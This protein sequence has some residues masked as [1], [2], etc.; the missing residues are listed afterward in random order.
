MRTFT[1]SRATM[2][3]T[4]CAC[5]S[6]LLVMAPPPAHTVHQLLFHDL[7]EFNLEHQRGAWLD[8]GRGPAV[9]VGEIRRADQPALAA[10]LHR[11]DPF[12]EARDHVVQRKDRRL[13]PLTRG[14]EDGAVGERAVV[15]D[16]YGISGLG[17]CAGA[18]LES[19]DDHS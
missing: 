13:A 2:F 16:L 5:R 10:H 8:S 17:R 6:N 14:V 18:G 1:C 19:G 7:E 3:P 9:T 4:S 15:M 11:A 12:A